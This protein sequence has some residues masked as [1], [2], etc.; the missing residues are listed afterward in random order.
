VAALVLDCSVTLA[1]FL[2]ESASRDAADVLDRVV[3]G[4]AVVPL[5]WPLE[6]GNVLLVAERRGRIAPGTRLRALR[7]LS[8]L[9]ITCDLETPQYAWTG[10]MN[11]AVEHG[12]TL[13][14]AAYLELAVRR[15]LPLAT[16]DR[17]LGAAAAAVGISAGIK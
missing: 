6:V 16:F 8:E 3:E 10:A 17:A 7:A 11:L 5:L 15:N 9:P 14:D 1:W 13:Y 4:G 12:L 2:A